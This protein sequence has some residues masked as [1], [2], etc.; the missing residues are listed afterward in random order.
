[1]NI[2]VIKPTHFTVNEWVFP[3]NGTYKFKILNDGSVGLTDTSMSGHYI[4]PPVIYSEWV[5]EDLTPYASLE[6]LKNSIFKVLNSYDGYLSNPGLLIDYNLTNG[7][8]DNCNVN[9]SVTPVV[10][11]SIASADSVIT[12]FKIYIEDNA[13]FDDITFGGLPQLANGCLLFLDGVV[14]G[15]FRTNKEIALRSSSIESFTLFSSANKN[16]LSTR[17]FKPYLTLNKGASIRFVVQD[18]LTGLISLNF[19]IRGFKI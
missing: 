3:K 6:E 5:K 2:L 12:E 9:G 19:G 10:F 18:N 1:M 15:I 8:T 4:V 17:L 13:N 16:M 7:V 14:A 11:E